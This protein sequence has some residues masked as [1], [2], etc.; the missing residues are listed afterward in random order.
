MLSPDVTPNSW[1]GSKHQLTHPDLHHDKVLCYQYQPNNSVLLTM[2]M[3]WIK[4]RQGKKDLN[5]K[6]CTWTRLLK[7]L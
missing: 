3:F 5:T 6:S 2:Y 7:H 4:K 1:L